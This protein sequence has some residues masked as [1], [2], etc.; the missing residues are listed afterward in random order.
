MEDK[1][2]KG[3]L[4]LQDLLYKLL[5]AQRWLAAFICFNVKFS[6]G[7]TGGFFFLSFSFFSFCKNVM[8]CV[9][10]IKLQEP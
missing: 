7:N 9:D 8:F 5:K 1:G 4:Y 3:K 6:R 10:K 2:P